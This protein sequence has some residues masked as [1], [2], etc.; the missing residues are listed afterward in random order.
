MPP[1]TNRPFRNRDL[2]PLDKATVLQIVAGDSA[3]PA[4]RAAIGTVAA[5]STA[6]ARA[7]V[8]CSHPLKAE[9][10]AQGG[11]FLPLPWSNKNPLAMVLSVHRLARLI[12]TERA[13]IVH[14]GSRAL[15]WAALA[16]T[17]ITKTPLVTNYGAGY[18]LR[19]P[20]SAR[21]NSALA[22]GDAVVA[23]SN[24]AAAIAAKHFPPAAGKVRV[25]RRGIDR[26]V[27]APGAV[28]PARV[29]AI[30]EQW[31]IAPHEQ[32]V[33][34]LAPS[35]GSPAAG[36]MIEAVRLLSRSGL[37][38]VKFVASCGKNAEALHGRSLECAIAREGLKGIM[39]R[40]GEGDMPAALLAATLVAVLPAA[41][42]LAIGEAAIQA[43]AMGTPVIAA[44]VGAAPEI[45]LA[46]PL[47][48]EQER[49]G[50]LVPPGDAPAL[51]L[52]IATALTLGA[53]ARS[54]LAARAIAHVEKHYSA[55]RMYAQIL[56]V[57]AGLR[58]GRDAAGSGNSP[59][60]RN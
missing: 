25:I 3:A 18:D 7:L 40:A 47:V 28:A 33:L 9:L 60:G 55:Q 49:T 26:Q 38:G 34:L 31:N 2:H 14:V 45:V 29:E 10:H 4:S 57:Y 58:L 8:A 13:D 17:R 48:A 15:A 22:R 54:R 52:A 46:P 35:T 32:L 56:E 44:N 42:T 41:G 53:S 16:A 6:G 5:L 1:F 11:T 36:A 51:A 43:Q 39:H 37:S 20:V 24:F 23:A 30:R 27:F 21:Y 19:N 50:F 59:A 12:E